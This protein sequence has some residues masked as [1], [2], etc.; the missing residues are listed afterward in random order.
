MRNVRKLLLLA[1]MALTAAAIAAP[2]AL[3]QSNPENHE[4][5]EITNEVTGQHCPAVTKLPHQ[6]TGGCLIHAKSN[7]PVE[8]RK[9]VFGIESHITTCENEF[10]GVVNEDAEG[11]IIHQVLTGANCQR[12]ACREDGEPERTPWPAH[13]DE[14]H[15]VS[16]PRGETGLVTPVAGHTEILTTNFCVVPL[17]MSGNESCEIDVPFNQTATTHEYEFGDAAVEM[18]SHGVSGFRCELVGHWRTEHVNGTL[19]NIP[20]GRAEVKVEVKH[21][22]AENKAENP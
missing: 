17:N 13:G 19:E 8:L 12:E 11:S 1:I 3:A 4:T 18:A 6:S 10:W 14:L 9:H 21:V 16:P 7:G 22:E 15:K 5:L 20:G 2:A